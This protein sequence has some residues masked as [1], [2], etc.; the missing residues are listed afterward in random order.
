MGQI[1]P[2]SSMFLIYVNIPA[3]RVDAYRLFLT[4]PHI[5]G[6]ICPLVL[7]NYCIIVIVIY[8]MHM[9]DYL[10]VVLLKCHCYYYQ[11]RGNTIVSDHLMYMCYPFCLICMY[12]YYVYVLCI[13]WIKLILLNSMFEVLCKCQLMITFGHHCILY[14]SLIL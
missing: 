8:I 10:C 3:S 12:A 1:F 2:F 11:P 9:H 14:I 7:Y 6:I 5:H 4:M 13:I